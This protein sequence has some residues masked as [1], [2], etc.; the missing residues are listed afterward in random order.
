MVDISTMIKMLS[1][2]HSPIRHS[3][4]SLLLELSKC[5]SF[6]YKIG[7]VA[8]GIL[9]LITVKYKQSV[10]A[11]ASETADQILNN[12]ESLPENIKLMAENGYWEPLLNHLAKGNIKRHALLIFISV[13]LI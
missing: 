6:C 7:A 11:L 3:S 9:M 13:I 5:R 4:A 8:G 10:D 1:S 12:L 2:N